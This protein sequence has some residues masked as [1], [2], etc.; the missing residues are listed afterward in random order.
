MATPIEFGYFAPTGSALA[1]AQAFE[2]AL[3]RALAL[4]HTGYVLDM[5]RNAF[6]G[7]GRELLHDPNVARLYLGGSAAIASS[8]NSTSRMASWDT[9]RR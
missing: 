9:N 2:P 6:S 3:R 1:R 5:G 8:S 4:A 7:P